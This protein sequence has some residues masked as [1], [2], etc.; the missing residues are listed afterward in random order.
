ML[1]TGQVAL[2]SDALMWFR[3]GLAAA[4]SND[5]AQAVAHYNRVLELQSDCY[6][7]WYERG[8]ALER[9]GYYIEAIASYDRALSLSPPL[10]ATCEIWHDRGNSYQYGMGDYAQ[11]IFCYD[12]VAKLNPDHEASWQNRGNANLYGL[13]LSET[14]LDCYNRALTINPSNELAWRNRGNALVELRRFNDAIASYDRALA[15]RP[16]DQV[17]WHAR[18]LAAEK[19][20]LGDRQPT[21]NPILSS[22]SYHDQTFVEGSSNSK[23]AFASH[24]AAT[25]EAFSQGQPLLIVEDDWGRREI[26]LELDQYILGR[27]PQSD[28]CLHSQYVSRQHAVLTKVTKLEGECAYQ[29]TD[30]DPKGKAS[31]NGLLINSHKCRMLELTA[32]DV[33]VFGPGARATYRFLPPTT[34]SNRF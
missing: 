3:Q 9:Q 16:E 19:A 14:A 29:I 31:T 5:F 23:P 33:I 2:N 12:Q 8:L 13:G 26:I 18:N 17:S 10:D 27:D 1:D 24:N 4:S 34:P 22:S 6:E 21:T 28:I 25:D 11:A 30:G 7:V 15:I 20:G 32:G